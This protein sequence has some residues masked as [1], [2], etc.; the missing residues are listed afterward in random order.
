MIED[1]KVVLRCCVNWMIAD[2]HVT[3]HRVWHVR[4]CGGG[5]CLCMM[6]AARVMLCA[7]PPWGGRRQGCGW[8]QQSL[9][10][11]TSSQCRVVTRH[12][13]QRGLLSPVRDG[14]RLVTKYYGAFDSSL[15]TD[16]RE[17][18]WHQYEMGWDLLQN[19]TVHLIAPLSPTWGRH[20]V[21]SMKWGVTVDFVE[22]C[23]SHQCG[24]KRC[25]VV[26]SVLFIDIVWPFF[27][28]SLFPSPSLQ[29]F[30]TFSHHEFMWQKCSETSLLFEPRNRLMQCV[31]NRSMPCVW[32]E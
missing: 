7:V 4:L 20:A 5:D 27:F 23:Y 6:I 32:C 18:C 9:V 12:R 29:L 17:A 31:V 26:Y 11:R 21:I 16:L 13:L 24:T 3:L 14:V 1:D 22:L 19:I 30:P 8:P 15:V 2:Y 10:Q 28:P 25:V